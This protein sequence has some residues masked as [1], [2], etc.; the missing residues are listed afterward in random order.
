[1]EFRPFERIMLPILIVSQ[2]IPKIAI[3]PLFLIWFGLGWEPKVLIAATI[4]F[5]PVVI[6]MVTGMQSMPISLLELAKSMGTSRFQTM[7]RFRMPYAL[8]SLFAGIKVSITLAVLG[9]IV[10][11][12][13][14]A[15]QGLG[16]ILLR[17]G[18]LM[19][20]PLMFAAVVVLAAVGM[21]LFYVAQIVQRICLPWHVSTQIEVRDGPA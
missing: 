19:E 12:F 2:T 18:G 8:P 3:A 1:V 9:A 4:A 17:A 5:F 10:G 6:S 21:L 20:T 11:E 15:A 16:Y 14:G 7:T 13:M